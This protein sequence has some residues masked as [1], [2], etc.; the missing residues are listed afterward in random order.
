MYWSKVKNLESLDT[1]KSFKDDWLQ[2]NWELIVERR[3]GNFDLYLEIYGEGTGYNVE[4]SRVLF[5]DKQATHNIILSSKNEDKLYDCLGESLIDDKIE[6]IIFQKFVTIKADSWY[7]EEMPF[8]MIEA[9]YKDE[10]VIISFDAINAKIAA[11][12]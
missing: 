10:V 8:N 6:S 7:Y 3:L 4:S 1:T 9:L 11:I 5:P 12:H 2:A